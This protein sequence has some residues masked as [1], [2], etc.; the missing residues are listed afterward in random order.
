LEE[1]EIAQ[2]GI[3]TD[4]TTP[5]GSPVYYIN[6]T[7]T[8]PNILNDDGFWTPINIFIADGFSFIVE[9]LPENIVDFMGYVIRIN[10]GT[11]VEFSVRLTDPTE[12]EDRLRKDLLVRIPGDPNAV[13]IK[14]S[15][16]HI[17]VNGELWQYGVS[18]NSSHISYWFNCTEGSTVAT[19]ENAAIFFVG[20]NSTLE[21]G[22]EVYPFYVSIT[23]AVA[24]VCNISMCFQHCRY[25]LCI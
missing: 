15:P 21:I 20:D 2:R 6:T 17:P 5:N 3:L 4:R 16:D 25:L 7:L 8:N 11:D 14:L 1:V 23:L 19:V 22:N 24:I 18:G 10:S 12:A 13:R 9:W